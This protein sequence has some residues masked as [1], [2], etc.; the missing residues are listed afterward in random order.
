[1][2]STLLLIFAFLTFTLFSSLS[3][4]C[5]PRPSQVVSSLCTPRAYVNANDIHQFMPKSNL[6]ISTSLPPIQM[7]IIGI[8]IQLHQWL[9]LG[10]FEGNQANHN[11]ISSSFLSSNRG[12]SPYQYH[13]QLRCHSITWNIQWAVVSKTTGGARTTERLVCQ[14]GEELIPP[15]LTA[16]NIVSAYCYRKMLK[17]SKHHTC[18]L[19]LI[20]PASPISVDTL[21][22]VVQCFIMHLW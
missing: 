12:A 16:S 18:C 14:K 9:Y 7:Q 20:L 6:A 3:F 11:I 22:S 2:S 15:F 21:D 5:Q 19:V 4:S 17:L 13:W 10:F 1:M 8:E